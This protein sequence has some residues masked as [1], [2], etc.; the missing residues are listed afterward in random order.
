[1]C[2]EQKAKLEDALHQL[3]ENKTV[4]DTQHRNYNAIIQKLAEEGQAVDTHVENIIQQAE[5]PKCSILHLASVEGVIVL[6]SSVCLVVCLCVHLSHYPGQTNRHT[7][8][9]SG[10]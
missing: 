6:T 1:M 7:G 8:L 2:S 10:M 4:L 9:N 5:V 3:T